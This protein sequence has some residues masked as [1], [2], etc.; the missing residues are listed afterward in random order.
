MS[1]CLYCCHRTTRLME[2]IATA[3]PTIYTYLVQY[4]GGF[5]WY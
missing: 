3:H 1:T 4:G 5:H 2:H